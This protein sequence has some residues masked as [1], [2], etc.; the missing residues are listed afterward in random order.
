M[1]P[2]PYWSNNKRTLLR[3]DCSVPVPTAGD[4]AI[5]DRRGDAPNKPGPAV[6]IQGQGLFGPAGEAYRNDCRSGVEVNGW[7]SLT[8]GPEPEVLCKFAED[9]GDRAFVALHQVGVPRKLDE[10]SQ[11]GVKISDRLRPRELG[12]H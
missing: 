5:E 8:E 3:R 11:T 6:V 10:T 12:G 4:V 7:R 2:D 1:R 9:G